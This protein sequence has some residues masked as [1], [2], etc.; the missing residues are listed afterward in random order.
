MATNAATVQMNT[1]LDALLKRAGDAVLAL[2]GLTPSKA[3]RFLWRYLAYTQ[4]LPAFMR[5]GIVEDA[6]LAIKRAAAAEG[7]GMLKRLAQQHGYE[8]RPSLYLD[9]AR[10]EMYDAQL[11]ELLTFHETGD[12]ESPAAHRVRG[13]DRVGNVGVKRKAG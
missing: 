4:E 13:G 6:E 11:D 5:S 12:P 10:A 7:A 1:R 8:V 9:E 2:N 3:V